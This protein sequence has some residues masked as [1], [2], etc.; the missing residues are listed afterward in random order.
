MLL[1]YPPPPPPHPP[2]R[3]PQLNNVILKESQETSLVNN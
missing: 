2:G 1:P 3:K